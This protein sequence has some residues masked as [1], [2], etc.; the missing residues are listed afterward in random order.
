MNCFACE[1]NLSAYLDDELPM[2]E[3]LEI[4]AHLD[5]CERCRAEFESHQGTWEMG[6]ENGPLVNSLPRIFQTVLW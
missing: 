6:N 4:E 3:R 1:R 5:A 2:D